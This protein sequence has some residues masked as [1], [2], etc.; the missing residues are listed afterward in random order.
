MQSTDP[1][2]GAC[3]AFPPAGSAMAIAGIGADLRF[4]FV[5]G[6]KT[7]RRLWD[8]L[9]GGFPCGTVY[10]GINDTVDSCRHVHERLGIGNRC[11]V[12]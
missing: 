8:L 1:A 3:T 10:P 2:F 5:N 9:S 11:P 7:T 12:Y 6:V 4:Q